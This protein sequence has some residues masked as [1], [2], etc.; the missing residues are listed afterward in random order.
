MVLRNFDPME[1]SSKKAKLDARNVKL[2]L[3]G[4]QSFVSRRGIDGLL[5]T[6]QREGLPSAFSRSTQYRARKSVCKT[7]TPYGQLVEEV[8]LTLGDKGTTIG[9]Q[10]PWAMLYYA[11]STSDDVSALVARTI[12]TYPP[13]I[14]KPWKIILYSDGVDPSDG[15]SVNKSRKSNV[16]YWTFLEF[17]HKA[18]AC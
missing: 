1:P 18:L 3:L 12:E 5:R 9:F 11:T 14:D 8:E 15:L 16:F 2:M 17:D 6:V 13:S 7:R 4:R 10:N